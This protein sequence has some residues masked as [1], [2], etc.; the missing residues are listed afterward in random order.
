[1]LDGLRTIACY[2][3][4][5]SI[6]GGLW[7]YAVLQQRI[8]LGDRHMLPPA[9]PAVLRRVREIANNDAWRD[10]QQPRPV[11]RNTTA[12]TRVENGE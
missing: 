9:D 10:P 6:L 4:V 3:L 1:M 7:A 8:S 12:V 2:A 5:A 11:A